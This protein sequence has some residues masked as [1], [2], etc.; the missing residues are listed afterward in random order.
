M[1]VMRHSELDDALPNPFPGPVGLRTRPTGPPPSNK[2]APRASQ[3][4]QQ[5][6]NDR[7]TRRQRPSVLEFKAGQ[8]ET[9]PIHS[10]R[11]TTISKYDLVFHVWCIHGT[12]GPNRKRKHHTS[13]I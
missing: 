1:V 10:S 9:L 11:T 7:S 2:S 13:T 3:S 12:K 8:V 6:I 5:P 4:N